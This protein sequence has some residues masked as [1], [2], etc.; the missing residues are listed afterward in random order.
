MSSMVLFMLFAE[1]ESTAVSHSEE[2]YDSTTLFSSKIGNDIFLKLNR[3][4]LVVS[5]TS[6]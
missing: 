6:W 3:P 1:R 2:P 5:S 4:A